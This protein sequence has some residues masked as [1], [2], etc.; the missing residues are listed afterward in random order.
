[1]AIFVTHDVFREPAWGGLH[2]LSIGRQAGV[3]DV[4]A[5]MGWLPDTS[6]L[7]CTTASVAQLTGFHCPHYVE[8][9]RRACE[10][11]AVSAEVRERHHIGTMENPIFPG[12]YE[13]AAASVGGAIAAAHA[14]LKTTR[15]FHPAGGTHHGRRDRASGFCYFNDPVFAIQTLLDAG[16]APVL[17]VDI[18][19][20]HGD[21]VEAAFAGDRRV[22]FVSIHEEGRWPYSGRQS[23][24]NVHNFPVPP[25]LNDA[26]F[27]FLVEEPVCAIA[28]R[29]GPAA[30]VIVAGADCLAGDPLSSM[31]LSNT[32]F[33]RGV[34]S[35]CTMAPLQ[36]VLGGGGYNPWTTV[37]AWSGLWAQL[38]GLP[39]PEVAPA[40]VR[41]VLEGLSCDL[42]DDDERDPAWCERLCDPMSQAPP[43]E[44]IRQLAALAAAA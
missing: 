44:S 4:C 15:A 25:G 32:G 19:A 35:L 41:A 8:A 39:I 24:L 1:M 17:Y 3:I 23:H 26:E 21:G 14:A 16:A 28:K 12:A 36:V 43:R 37:R 27:C 11:G 5:A 30:I 13:R 2:P 20:H 10:T 42:I 33:W 9:F 6:M 34:A 38:A 40:P 22:E 29:V 7:R 31:A 18:D